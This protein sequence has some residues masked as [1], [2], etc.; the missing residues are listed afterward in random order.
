LE[1]PAGSADSPKHVCVSGK[2]VLPILPIWNVQ[3]LLAKN[4]EFVFENEIG[5]G[6][7]SCTESKITT[8]GNAICSESQKEF[9][10]TSHESKMCQKLKS[11]N[12]L[13][14]E[15]SN[16]CKTAALQAATLDTIQIRNQFTSVPAFVKK[17]E[18]NLTFLIK[19]YL[20]PFMRDVQ[21]KSV[22]VAENTFTTSMRIEFQKWARAFNLLIKRP[23]ES[24]TFK[25]IHIPYPLNLFVPIK[26][27]RD[28]FVLAASKITPFGGEMKCSIESG[29]IRKFNGKA[30]PINPIN[31]C[32]YLGAMDARPEKKEFVI[33]VKGEGAK[34]TAVIDIR[35]KKIAV[36][37]TSSPI[38]EVDGGNV[39]LP[40]QGQ[41]PLEIKDPKGRKAATVERFSDRVVLK[42][43]LLDS[44]MNYIRVVTNGDIIEISS[45]A[46]LRNKITGL[47]GSSN[48]NIKYGS[49]SGSGSGS[50][51]GN[52]GGAS[53]KC[54]YSKAALEVAAYQ[55][56]SGSCPSLESS[57]KT[58]LEKEKGRCAKKT[59]SQTMVFKGYIASSG[60][61][62]RQMHVSVERPG[63]LCISKVPITTCGP[64]G[65]PAGEKVKK[66]VPFV[67]IP[68]KTR[69]AE[70]I[71]HKINSGHMIGAE[72]GSLPES[73]KSSMEQPRNC[74]SAASGSGVEGIL[75]ASG[76]GSNGRRSGSGSNW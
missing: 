14:A 32:E 53:N 25:T 10:K 43:F 50:M 70:H 38:L 67:C 44:S 55:I 29:S 59:V 21:G 23:N 36:K 45:S 57:I 2:L 69:L 19:A 62:T 68:A 6:M 9:A 56:P 1:R 73:F 42:L 26:A 52:N 15:S 35:N 63:E 31:G 12:S 4:I 72:L 58:E 51:G 47:C 28:N 8:H 5:M 18:Q 66:D 33:K 46:A 16:A 71:A 48:L 49:G 64:L 22:M 76:Y 7:S 37:W 65:R 34:K 75:S 17:A 40:S 20:W 74:V 3:E 27:G 30:I 13:G 11:G 39:A 24:V 61:P 60:K 54:V 41:S